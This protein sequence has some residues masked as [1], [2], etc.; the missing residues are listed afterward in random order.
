MGIFGW[1]LPP[2]CSSN[3]IDRAFGDEG[4]CL[5]CGLAVDMCI[6]PECPQCGTQGDPGCYVHHGLTP[7]PEQVAG[8]QAMNDAQAEQDRLDAEEG[9]YWADTAARARE[10]IEMENYWRELQQHNAQVCREAP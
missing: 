7:T 3:D 2:G 6:C 8:V 4:P 10:A 9:A 1:S 5:C